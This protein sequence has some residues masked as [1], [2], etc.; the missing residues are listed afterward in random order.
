[1][2]VYITQLFK[3]VFDPIPLRLYTISSIK[4]IFFN[5]H[6]HPH[7]FI[8]QLQFKCNKKTNKDI[9]ETLLSVSFHL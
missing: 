1:M 5:M 2:Y 7:P 6:P 8:V 3:S 4:H 9:K